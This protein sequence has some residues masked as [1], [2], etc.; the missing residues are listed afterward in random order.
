MIVSELQNWTMLFCLSI[1]NFS[2]LIVL[3]F[4]VHPMYIER[5]RIVL[6]VSGGGGYVKP[7]GFF[8]EKCSL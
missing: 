3:V 7:Q 4:S 8:L 1:S 6:A 5:P 2:Y